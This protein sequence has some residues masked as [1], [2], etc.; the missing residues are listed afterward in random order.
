MD[1][2]INDN[3]LTALYGLPHLQQLAYLRGIRPYMDIRTNMVGIKRGI[4]YQ[5]ISEQIYVEPHQGIKS[6]TYSRMQVRRAL[7]SLVRVGLISVQSEGMKLILKCEL[8]SRPYS[9]QNKVDLKPTQQLDPVNNSFAPAN[10]NDLKENFD[11][12]DIGKTAKADTPLKDNNY[13]LFL[14]IKFWEKYPQQKSKPVAWAAFQS[15]NPDN[16]LFS[17]IMAA[18]EAQI[19]HYNHM[20]Q[21]GRWIAAWKNPAN[22]LSQQCW[23]DEISMDN[24]PETNHGMSA[25]KKHSDKAHAPKDLFWI[26]DDDEERGDNRTNVIQFQRSQS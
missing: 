8:A 7:A 14:F 6:E 26:P 15:L 25:R 20:Q 5:S 10:I 16:A 4:S 18:L 17:K 2:S 19:T 21:S 1:F 13:L 23:E 22:W 24:L 12:A 3:E 9:V 11:K